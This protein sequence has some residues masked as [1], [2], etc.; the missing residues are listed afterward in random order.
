MRWETYQVS[1]L[2]LSVIRRNCS[3]CPTRCCTNSAPLISS[4]FTGER[5]LLHHCHHW[6]LGVRAGSESAEQPQLCAQSCLTAD[7]GHWLD[8]Q[9]GLGTQLGTTGTVSPLST[10]LSDDN[11]GYQQPSYYSVGM[12]LS[13]QFCE[14]E[15]YRSLWVWYYMQRCSPY[16]MLMML[17]TR[18]AYDNS[19]VSPVYL[20]PRQG[21]GETITEQRTPLECNDLLYSL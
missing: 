2:S 14:Q 1:E 13:E 5:R 21:W 4:G 20:D 17:Y 12:W 6:Y 7:C 19:R 15:F 18:I 8:Q 3:Y 11:I 10:I 16:D 9:S